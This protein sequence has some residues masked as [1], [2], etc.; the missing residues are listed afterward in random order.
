MGR[1][2]VGAGVR[3]LVMDARGVGLEE[4]WWGI[5]GEG[6]VLRFWRY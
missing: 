6:G 3:P 1:V 5:G 2:V 4:T